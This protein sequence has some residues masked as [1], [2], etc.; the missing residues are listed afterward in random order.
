MDAAIG[1][2]LQLFLLVA[3]AATCWGIWEWVSEWIEDLRDHTR[4]PTAQHPPAYGRAHPPPPP[5]S[6]RPTTP[7]VLDN[8]EPASH[9]Q[10][11]YIDSDFGAGLL[12]GKR[13]S[14]SE[15]ATAAPAGSPK[16][17]PV[18][19]P[20]LRL[21]RDADGTLVALVPQGL[22]RRHIA[23]FFDHLEEHGG[24]ERVRLARGT[25]TVV[26]QLAMEART[27]GFEISWHKARSF[28]QC[29]WLLERRK[30]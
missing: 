12:G 18:W 19:L 9:P 20:Q 30:P 21:S 5:P 15:A 14:T 28:E 25:S 6:Y 11:R 22:Q 27:R 7:H 8:W 24:A 10:P 13:A 2:I 16:V 29:G 26:D 3:V 4:V 1:C 17:G 23:E